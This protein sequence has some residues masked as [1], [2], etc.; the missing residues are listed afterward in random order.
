MTLASRAY[1]P[2]SRGIVLGVIGATVGIGGAIGP[3]VG[4]ALANI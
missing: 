4:G 1:G 2:Q 3:L